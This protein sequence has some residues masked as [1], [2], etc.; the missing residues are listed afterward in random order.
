VRLIALTAALALTAVA[1]ATSQA[2]A[3]DGS[4][5]GFVLLGWK[6]DTY[7]QPRSD[8]ALRRMAAD[9]ASHV[10]IFSQWF[11]PDRSASALAPDP[12][13][14]PSDASILHAM[15]VARGL[16][17][18][19]T[20]KP[21]VG[22]DSGG[23]IG[24][25]RPSDAADFWKR[26][27]AMLLHYAV[28]A[29]RG[30]ASVLVIGTEMATM[31]GDAN[32]WRALIAEVRKRFAGALT[33]AA[34]YDEFERVPFWDAL[35]YVG[36]DA[37]FP[38]AEAGRPSS[39][40]APLAAAWGEHVDAI[41]RFSRKTGRRVLFTELGYRAI[42]ATAVHPS[43]WKAAGAPDTRAQA[44]AYQAFY[45]AVAKQPWMAGVYW[46]AVNPDGA[47]PQDYDP[48]GKP[49]E[50]IVRRENVRAMLPP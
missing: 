44:N 14:T 16:G 50:V 31:S 10:A 27:S 28:L 1:I 9:G 3:H 32:R 20:L 15:S 2:P 42:G 12:A 36:I 4:Q 47:P 26:Y 39:S 34:N 29:H 18:K 43:D 37:Y 45:D 33:Y 7:L 13:R 23:W 22:I 38:L 17:L 40:S 46:W 30:G 41:A 48:V 19:V 8:A 5:R 21:Q 25:A 6:S 24:A 11:L 49:A 35:D